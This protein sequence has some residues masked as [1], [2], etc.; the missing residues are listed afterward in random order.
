M[1][2]KNALPVLIPFMFLASLGWGQA[3]SAT[4]PADTSRQDSLKKR[5]NYYENATV[6]IIYNWAPDAPEIYRNVCCELVKEK[7]KITE[8]IIYQEDCKQ[9]IQV[10]EDF[11]QFEVRDARTG[12][13]IARSR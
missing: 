1:R 3:G 5:P 6:K 8:I 13:L 2:F 4:S 12:K 7:G 11:V 9:R 10:A